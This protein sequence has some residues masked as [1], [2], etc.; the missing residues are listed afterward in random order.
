MTLTHDIR[1][2]REVIEKKEDVLNR[3]HIISVEAIT[4]FVDPRGDLHTRIDE[5][6]IDQIDDTE[7]LIELYAFLASRIRMDTSIYWTS[8]ASLKTRPTHL[9]IDSAFNALSA[10][11]SHSPRLKTKA[12]VGRKW[13]MEKEKE[14]VVD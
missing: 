11:S 5:Q 2:K 8:N 6:T 7:Y 4:E 10:N 3:V 13:E 1:G 14:K 9:D 12:I